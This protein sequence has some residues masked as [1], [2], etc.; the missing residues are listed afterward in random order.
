MQVTGNPAAGIGGEYCGVGIG[1]PLVVLWGVGDPSTLTDP[2]VLTAA[3]GS[4][5][6]R[7][8]PPDATH[9][10]YVKV[11]FPNVWAAK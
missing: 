5:W 4:Q 9:G 6:M 2:S 8:D 11:A 3:P 7:L 1:G 10:M